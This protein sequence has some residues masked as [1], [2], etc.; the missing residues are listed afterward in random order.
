VALNEAAV[1]WRA[2]RMDRAAAL[3]ERAERVW[4]ESGWTD[5]ATLARSLVVAAVGDAAA[6]PDAIEALARDAERCSIAGIGIQAVG[7][8]ARAVGRS[9][10]AAETAEQLS[11]TVAREHWGERMEVTSVREARAALGLGGER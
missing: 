9:P 2:R 7:L 5:G 1:A 4:T 6:R 11:A 8:L 10:V 3:A